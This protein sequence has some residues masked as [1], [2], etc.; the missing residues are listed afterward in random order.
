MAHSPRAVRLVLQGW[1]HGPEETVVEA[2]R[3][4]EAGSAQPVA[5][6]RH[7]LDRV[8]RERVGIEPTEVQKDPSWF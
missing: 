1:C 2:V 4:T 5:P 6:T 7:K 8:W 3:V